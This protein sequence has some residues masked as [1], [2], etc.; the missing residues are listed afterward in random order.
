MVELYIKWA[1]MRGSLRLLGASSFEYVTP[2][3]GDHGAGAWVYPGIGTGSDPYWEA[4]S[5]S[6]IQSSG[7]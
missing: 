3:D 1:I 4:S 2:P 6:S 7:E 5:T